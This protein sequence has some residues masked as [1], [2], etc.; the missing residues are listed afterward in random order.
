[1]QHYC[2]MARENNTDRHRSRSSFVKNSQMACRQLDLD[3]GIAIKFMVSVVLSSD[4]PKVV[5]SNS[6]Q[7][8]WYSF[9]CSM[10]DWE[11]RFR[12]H[13]LLLQLLDLALLPGL[14]T[15]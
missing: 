12:R 8:P 15:C 4:Q 10:A 14:R 5:S 7:H 1:M 11:H 2:R 9:P 6:H 13:K 3:V